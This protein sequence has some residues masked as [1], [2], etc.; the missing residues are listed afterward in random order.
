M[1]AWPKGQG[2]SYQTRMN[3]ILRD[4]VGLEEAV[5]RLVALDTPGAGA[6]GVTVIRPAL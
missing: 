6:G 1:L 3:T 2:K 4:E 5:R